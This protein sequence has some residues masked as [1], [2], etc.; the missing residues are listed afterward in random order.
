MYVCTTQIY[1]FFNNKISIQVLDTELKINRQTTT[2]TF[3]VQV[4]P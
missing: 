4:L 1:S 2:G 3:K